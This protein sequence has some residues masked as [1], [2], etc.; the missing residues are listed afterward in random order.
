[1]S[2]FHIGSNV[3]F[4]SSQF[5][6]PHTQIRMALLLG[7][8]VSIPNWKP[9]P[10]PF[11]KEL[12]R[13]ALPITVLPKDDRTDFVQEERLDLPYWTKICAMCVVVDES[14]C[15]DILTLEFFLITS[16]H[17]PFWPE[18]K[19]IL[20]PLLVLRNLAVWIWCPRPL[21]LSF[22]MLMI[23]VQWILHKTLNRLSQCLPWVRL[24]LCTFDV[25]APIQRF[26]ND[27]VHQWG[28][29]NFC[30]RRPYFIDHLFLT[31]DLRQ[32]LRR[33]FLQF[34]PFLFHSCLCCRNFIAWGLGMN[35][36]TK[37]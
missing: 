13:I 2:I 7:Q 12:S 22:A 18:Y 37:L 11:F 19:R 15:L 27:I 3:L 35:L 26:S 6:H 30:A 24:C 8:R 36:C 25:E 14:K 20:H 9:S 16:V 31:S 34:F 1:M 32:V 4:L 33:N 10:Q 21:L 5:C 28:E 17:L 23:L 29:M